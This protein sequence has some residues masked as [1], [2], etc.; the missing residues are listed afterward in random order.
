MHGAAV[1]GSAYAR[2][3]TEASVLAE[4]KMEVLRTLPLAG[5]GDGS[6]QVDAQGIPEPDGP[7]TRSWT[8]A[9]DGPL[10]SVAVTVTWQ[11]QGSEPHAITFRTQRGL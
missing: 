4:D 11:E 8:I 10:A 2:H 5:F 1:R 9:A 7:Y 3:A 6:E